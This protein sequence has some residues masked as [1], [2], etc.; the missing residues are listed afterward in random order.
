MNGIYFD[1]G[2]VEERAGP[3][4]EPSIASSGSAASRAQKRSDLAKMVMPDIGENQR[5]ERDAKQDAREGQG[6][7]SG[8]GWHHRGRQRWRGEAKKQ[9]WTRRGG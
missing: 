8:Q 6:E 7:Q 2:C 3:A 4:A 9:G 1:S 5:P